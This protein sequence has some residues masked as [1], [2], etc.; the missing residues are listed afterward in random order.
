MEYTQ[1]ASWLSGQFIIDT[2]G[3]GILSSRFIGSRNTLEIK[4]GMLGQCLY[5]PGKGYCFFFVD[6]T[7]EGYALCMNM[8]TQL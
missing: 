7:R 1:D 3:L 5:V 8:E 2:K 4:K 6:I